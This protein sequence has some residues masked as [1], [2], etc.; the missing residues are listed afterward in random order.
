MGTLQVGT[1]PW[2]G[3]VVPLVPIDEEDCHV[4]VPFGGSNVFIPKT[5]RE[6]NYM[7][8]RKIMTV[9]HMHTTLAFL[10]LVQHMKDTGATPDEMVAGESACMSLP[11]IEYDES[12]S[13]PD[14]YIWCWA[15]AQVLLLMSEHDRST[16][17]KS[18]KVTTDEDLNKDLLERAK[19]KLKR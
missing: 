14:N 9:N 12:V 18:H 3:T 10:T 5:I 2:E 4:P 13:P 7:Y 16:M 6:S 17:R 19:T 1:E 8:D 15:V 11:L